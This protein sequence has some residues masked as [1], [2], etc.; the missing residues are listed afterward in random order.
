MQPAEDPTQQSYQL[1]DGRSLSFAEYGAPQGRPLF[2]F[3]GWPSSRI[4]FAGLNGDAIA[5]ELNVRVIAMD[6][7]GF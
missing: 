7:H 5:A 6:R 2:Y 1:P 3:H 4:E